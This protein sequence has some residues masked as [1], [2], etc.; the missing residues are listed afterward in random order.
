MVTNESFIYGWVAHFAYY[1]YSYLHTDSPA[2]PVV[3]VSGNR[4]VCFESNPEIQ[5]FQV[6][7]ILASRSMTPLLNDTFD[8]C[9]C[10]D[11]NNILSILVPPYCEILEISV[12]ASNE[13]GSSS[14]HI[15]AVVNDT[16]GIT[17]QRSP[18]L[19]TPLDSTLNFFLSRVWN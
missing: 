3:R 15:N 5:N 17:G 1:Y 2:L 7:V 8:L 11:I 19:T 4:T 16:T 18:H 6:L 9:Q 12:T 13:N 14:T 10:I